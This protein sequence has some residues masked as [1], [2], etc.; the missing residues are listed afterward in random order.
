MAGVPR[1]LKVAHKFG[2]RRFDVPGTPPTDQLHD[3]G[4]VYFP[5]RPYLLCLMTRGASWD[6]L[7]DT[8]RELS[9]IVYQHYEQVHLNPQGVVSSGSP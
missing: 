5:G 6:R 4:V 9:G 3:C 2:E 1:D 7:A 8:L